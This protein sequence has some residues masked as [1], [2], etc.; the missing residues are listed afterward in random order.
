MQSGIQISNPP[1]LH[2]LH[3]EAA[4]FRQVG[5]SGGF[6]QIAM[7]SSVPQ[8]SAVGVTVGVLVIVP[9][10]VGV[11]VLVGVRVIVGVLLGPG[12]GVSVFA[13]PAVPVNVGGTSGVMVTVGGGG[14]GS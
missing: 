12:V 3:L 5:K 10:G 8:S 9:V 11:R 4:Q 6:S 14:G 1:F 7:S 2:R 13:G